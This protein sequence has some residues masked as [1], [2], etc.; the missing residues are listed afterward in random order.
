MGWCPRTWLACTHLLLE[1][2]RPIIIVWIRMIGS[3]R[4]ARSQGLRHVTIEM[5]CALITS[6]TRP[7]IHLRRPRAVYRGQHATARTEGRTDK[8]RRIS[9]RDSEK[10]LAM[11]RVAPAT[12]RGRADARKTRF[13]PCAAPSARS[14]G[15]APRARR[16]PI[17][18]SW[19]HGISP[20]PVQPDAGEQLRAGRRNWKRADQPLLDERFSTFVAAF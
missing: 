2:L 6:A 8:G 1:T 10:R 4:L 12:R 7:S 18:A 14:T 15:C 13:I 20:D 3:V 11:M 16:M 9:G 5:P 17:R 19:N